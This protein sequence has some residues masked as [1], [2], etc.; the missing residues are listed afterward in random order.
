MERFLE[1]GGSEWEFGKFMPKLNLAETDK[2]YE[3]TVELP[4]LKPEEVNVELRE[5]QLWITGEKLEEKE[6]KGKAFH[7]IERRCGEFR[8]VIPLA[9]PVQDGKV[10][11][12]F[13]N[14]ILLVRIPKSEQV[15]PKKIKVKSAEN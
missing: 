7:M 2:L 15:L 10:E 6:E 8:R 1:Q 11:A 12:I 5:G 13:E 9:L 4:G 14:G 3:I